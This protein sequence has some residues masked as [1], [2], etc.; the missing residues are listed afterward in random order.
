M[1]QATSGQRWI[2]IHRA[3]L[4]HMAEGDKRLSKSF[5]QQLSTETK[6]PAFIRWSQSFM[7]RANVYSLTNPP[8][9]QPEA[10]KTRQA[11]PKLLTPDEAAVML[12]MSKASIY[13]L[14]ETRAL[15]FYRVSASLRF[16]EGDVQNYL[17][18]RRIE[19]IQR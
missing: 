14:V 16:S 7:M 17:S 12:R 8:T 5:P 1:S 18:G 13:R 15:P 4:G 6:G 10:L 19:P 11:L 3:T 2:L 9:M